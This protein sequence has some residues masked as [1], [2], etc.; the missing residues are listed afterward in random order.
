MAVICAEIRTPTTKIV[1]AEYCD[2]HNAGHPGDHLSSRAVHRKLWA[3]VIVGSSLAGRYH[4]IAMS[5]ATCRP[6]LR[7][8]L[9]RRKIGDFKK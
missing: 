1:F 7:D 6:D 2:Q 8:G 9:P 3:E 4:E 5:A